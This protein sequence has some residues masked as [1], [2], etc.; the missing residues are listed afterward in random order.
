[1]DL[2]ACLGCCEYLPQ[3]LASLS[4][5]IFTNWISLFIELLSL[6]VHITVKHS[7]AHSPHG[8]NC[9]WRA[10]HFTSY[11][12][13]SVHHPLRQPHPNRTHT[14]VHNQAQ[15]QPTQHTST[16]AHTSPVLTS[17]KWDAHEHTKVHV[18]INECGQAQT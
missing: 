5:F 3:V 11:T 2:G 8:H 6:K 16:S 12:P 17:P 13:S 18:S 1:M 15:A 4:H 14:H 9:G 10:D 7:R